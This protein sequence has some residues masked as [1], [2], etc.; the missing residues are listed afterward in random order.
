[1][2]ND[3]I[4]FWFQSLLELHSIAGMK[5]D[6]HLCSFVEENYLDEQ[7]KAIK[8]LSDL[9]TKMNRAGDGVGLHIIDKELADKSWDGIGEEGGGGSI[10]EICLCANVDTIGP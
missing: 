3:C 4:N 6:A 10:V 5:K 8:E 7:V 1:M 2:K 9:L